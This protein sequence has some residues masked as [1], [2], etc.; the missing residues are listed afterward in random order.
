[1]QHNSCNSRKVRVQKRKKLSRFL[2]FNPTNSLKNPSKLQ[3]PF[4]HQNNDDES[5]KKRAK[6]PPGLVK[7][8]N[9][10]KHL[11]RLLHLGHYFASLTPTALF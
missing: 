1:M 5:E 8:E 2:K 11:S 4:K 7:I 9:C 10:K 6:L 3:F